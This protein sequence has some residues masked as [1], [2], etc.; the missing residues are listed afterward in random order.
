MVGVSKKETS[1]WGL[2]ITFGAAVAAGAGHIHTCELVY[3]GVAQ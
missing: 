3:Q 1:S 2:F